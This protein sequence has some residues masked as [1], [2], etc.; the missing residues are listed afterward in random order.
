M[1]RR[2]LL[3]LFAIVASTARAQTPIA[4]PE[5]PSGLS[6]AILPIVAADVDPI[7]PQRVMEAVRATVREAGY[8]VVSE[9]ALVRAMS[10]VRLSSPPSP[11]EVWRVTALAGAQRGLSIRVGVANGLYVGE[12]FVA[13]ADGSGPYRAEFRGDGGTFL[14][15]VVEAIR[16]TLPAPSTYDAEAARRYS[17]VATSTPPPATA[18]SWST[19]TFARTYANPRTRT[20]P[21]YGITFVSESAFGRAQGGRYYHHGLGARMDFAFGENVVVGLFAGYLNLDVGASRASNLL[22]FAQLED[23]LQ[24][25]STG[26][27]RF[28]LRLAFGYV[29][30]NGPFLRFSGGLRFPVG[31]PFELG[32][33][34]LAPTFWW[35]P[36][37]RRV[38]YDVGAELTYR[39]GPAR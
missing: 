29:P 20:E 27:A 7:V 26:R 35:I 17:A 15:Y 16:R 1:L 14:D 36:G 5:A 6:V 38:T 11:S 33:D 19:A 12:L 30:F 10:A 32:F 13:S 3:G 18:P 25:V 28:P 2:L 34:L 4:T 39:F 24:F 37:D 21:R 31:G 8:D 9:A 23:R 22:F